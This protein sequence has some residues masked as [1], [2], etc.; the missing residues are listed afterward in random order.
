MKI[1]VKGIRAQLF[2]AF[3]ALVL[4]IN[5]F[6]ARLNYLFVDVTKDIVATVMIEQ[7]ISQLKNHWQHG[8]Q[9]HLTSSYFKLYSYAQIAALGRL[10]SMVHE[11]KLFKY[12]AA[13]EYGYVVELPFLDNQDRYLVLVASDMLP[14]ES[15]ANVFS[16]FLI[17][18]AIA[19]MILAVLSTWFLASKLS[20]PLRTLTSSVMRQQPHTP[21]TIKGTDR[22][23][24]IGQLAK[25]FSETYGA[26]QDAWQREHDF[27]NDVSHELRTPI[28]LIRNTLTINNS[29]VFNQQ[30]CQLLEQATTTLHQTI[31]VLLALARKEN[32]IFSEC[33]IAPLVE[34]AV[35]AI[36]KS[37]PD[38]AFN[39]KLDVDDNLT[40]YGNPNL[41]SLLCQNLVNNGFYH[42]DGE[43]MRIYSKSGLLMFENPMRNIATRVNYQ[44]LGHGQYL[45]NR[46]SGAMHWHVSF[47]QSGELYQVEV[48]PV[49]PQ[50]SR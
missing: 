47:A 28:A 12:L 4:V 9:L 41:I 49:T 19:A 33:A 43:G 21:S 18:V 26:L 46:I 25:A 36:L 22:P 13:D 15:F 2:L 10:E 31:D 1:K 8:R 42:G 40:V 50:H 6:Y 32:M 5:L 3:A 30:E 14:L 23:D 44:G 17:S 34:R 39:V 38:S 7:E 11:Q 24:E 20:E 29:G 35:L 16:V 27:A 45:V 37:H 48:K